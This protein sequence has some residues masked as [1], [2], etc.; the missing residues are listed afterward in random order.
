MKQN[1]AGLASICILSTMVLVMLSSTGSL[2]I[3]ME[4]MVQARHPNDF[5]IYMDTSDMEKNQEVLDKIKTHCEA[6]QIAEKDTTDYRYYTVTGCLQKDH[7][8]FDQTKFDYLNDNGNLRIMMVM[9]LSGYCAMTGEKV[10]LSG[11]EMLLGTGRNSYKYSN[12]KLMDQVYKVK[13]KVRHFEGNGQVNSNIR[14]S[15]TV[16]LADDTF[17]ALYQQIKD[18][19]RY[20]MK[21]HEYYGFDVSLD[22]DAQLKLK[23]YMWQAAQDQ[24]ADSIDIECRETSRNDFV[25]LYGGMFMLGM[26]LGTLFVMAMVLIIYYKQVSEGYEDRR[27]FE[28]MQ[29]VGMSQQEVKKVIRS[30]ILMVFF[31]P[32]VA[33][34]VHMAVAFPMIQNLLKA[35]NMKNTELYRNGTIGVYLGFAVL[36][37]LIYSLTAKAYYRI[38]K[39][40]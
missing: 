30:Q 14:D 6:Y 32:L 37:I 9:P 19:Y 23:D 39:R 11:Q 28:I 4:D 36:Y 25:G 27:Q 1:A 21:I 13:G 29:K 8:L 38:V 26:F 10:E 31:L 20:D 33:A 35:F 2:M 24:G 34:G 5:G 7:V 12:M 17:D 15:F 40:A 3:G 16:V 22:K 18:A